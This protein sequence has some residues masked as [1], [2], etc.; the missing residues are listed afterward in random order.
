MEKDDFIVKNIHNH[1]SARMRAKLIKK[2]VMNKALSSSDAPLPS[3]SGSCRHYCGGSTSGLCHCVLH[4]A[5]SLSRD[6][7]VKARMHELH[8]IVINYEKF[9]KKTDFFN[10]IAGL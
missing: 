1:P 10:A 3:H 7:R 5:H 4:Q 9:E 6:K 8:S 2:E